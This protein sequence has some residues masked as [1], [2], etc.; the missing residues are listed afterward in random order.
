MKVFEYLQIL[1]D[2]LGESNSRNDKRKVLE[3][4]PECRRILNYIYDPFKKYNITSKNCKKMEAKLAP[5]VKKSKLSR[6]V[7]NSV[8]DPVHQSFFDF[9]DSL[10]SGEYSGHK[11]IKET[12]K[13]TKRWSDYE[14]VIY[15]IID[16]DI[17][18]RIG[19]KDI[20]AVYPKLIPIFEIALAEIYNEKTKKLVDENWFLSRKLD[21][22]RC[23][24]VLDGDVRFFSRSGKE[25][26]S[27]NVLKEILWPY[28][29]INKVLD[30]EVCAM[31][32]N[33]ADNFKGVVKEV[34]KKNHQ[35]ENPTYLLFDMIDLADF[36]VQ[37]SD[38]ILSD[39]LKEAEELANTI[40]SKH[41]EYLE[42]IPY[43]E[44]NLEAIR[45]EVAKNGWEGFMVRKNCE[46]KGKRSKDILKGKEFFDAEYEVVRVNESIIQVIRE[47]E[48]VEVPGM[49]SATIMHK[50]QEVNVGS[51][52]SQE[53]RIN[54]V[55]K[56][57]ELVGKVI[58]VQYK[59]ET[60]DKDGN[61]S[62]QFPV[63]K[64]IHGRKREV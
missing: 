50:G 8:H 28:R 24:T 18:C 25:Y 5:P 26:P 32:E 58:T 41:I 63:V 39:R 52:W 27:L 29:N 14:D 54:F 10:I 4:H 62:L 34:M 51:G 59:Q 12:L 3:N 11:A 23:V 38:V 53:Q 17:K 46:Y 6:F 64:A 19:A 30:G 47:N 45:E 2:E 40:D 9:L 55:E 36:N 61:V 22:I 15:R 42:Q 44:E 1:I 60:T 48:N 21:G 20:N 57:E 7:D 35:M 37:H 13:W 33:G 31:D 49:G 16:K 56:P 43:S